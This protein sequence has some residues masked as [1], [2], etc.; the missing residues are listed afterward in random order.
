MRKKIA[1]FLRGYQRTWEYLYQNTF[2]KFENV[3]GKEN[4]DWYVAFWKTNSTDFAK[5]SNMFNDKNLISLKLIDESSYPI[6]MVKRLSIHTTDFNQDLPYFCSSNHYNDSYWR[7]AYLDQILVLLKNVKEVETTQKYDQVL[8]TRPDILYSINN[9]EIEQYP[10]VDFFIYGTN[11]NYTGHLTV[12]PGDLFYKSTSLTA[13][14]ISSRFLDFYLTVNTKQYV[15]YC[16]HQLFGHYLQRHNV[17]EPNLHVYNTQSLIINPLLIEDIPLIKQSDFEK[18]MS[19]N[20][21]W[22]DLPTTEKHAI[23]LRYGIDPI[24]YINC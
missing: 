12:E 16:A 2:F 4:I 14:I 15:N 23:C 24:E 21:K 19:V 11:L 1:I 13:D 6:S 9:L 10:L 18:L 22:K 7:M 20:Y 8:F 3:F 17:R 5:I